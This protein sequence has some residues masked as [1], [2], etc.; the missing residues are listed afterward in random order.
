MPAPPQLPPWPADSYRERYFYWDE[1]AQVVCVDTD[2]WAS[3]VTKGRSAHKCRRQ[4]TIARTAKGVGVLKLPCGTWTCQNCAEQKVMRHLGRLHEVITT[5]DHTEL[6]VL[7]LRSDNERASFRQA[8][9]RSPRVVNGQDR[10]YLMVNREGVSY[11]LTTAVL[12]GRWATHSETM[13]VLQVWEFARTVA[14]ALPL[15]EPRPVTYS[16]G[17]QPASPDP[18]DST[19]YLVNATTSECLTSP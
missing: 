15:L 7:T 5:G 12:R 14:L 10:W 18:S 2:R 1:V 8:F 17:G 16:R 13:D 19:I 4:T 11:V 9:G 6:S 3:A